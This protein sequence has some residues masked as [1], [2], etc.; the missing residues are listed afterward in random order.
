MHI[1]VFAHACIHAYPPLAA[2]PSHPFLSSYTPV[3][4]L[5]HRVHVQYQPVDRRVA[6]SILEEEALHGGRP[7]R[8]E[9]RQKEEKP[10]EAGGLAGKARSDIVAEDALGLV[11]QHLHRMDVHQSARLWWE[12]K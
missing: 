12:T 10:A 3:I 7:D 6:Y 2:F 5:V 8:L 11:L 4:A 9:A 1:H